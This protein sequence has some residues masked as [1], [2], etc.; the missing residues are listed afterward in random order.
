MQYSEAHPASVFCFG[1]FFSYGGS[2]LHALLCIQIRVSY[3]TK[4]VVNSNII[5]LFT[6]DYREKRQKVKFE[7]EPVLNGGEAEQ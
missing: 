2:Y 1:R 3:G 5:L 4:P 6:I 7:V